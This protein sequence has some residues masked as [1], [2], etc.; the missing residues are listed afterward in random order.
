[1]KK[2]LFRLLSSFFVFALTSCGNTTVSQT[3]FAYSSFVSLNFYNEPSV[4][5]D[6]LEATIYKY[7]KYCDPYSGYE[8]VNNLYTINNATNFIDVD[9]DLLTLLKQSIELENTTEG[10]L[11]PLIG[12]LSLLWK[13]AIENET[14]PS[15]V[16]INRELEIMQNSKLIIE[17]NKVKIE[18]GA[19]LDLGAI[20][21][22]YVLNLLKEKFSKEDIK[23][24][25]ING[26][27]SSIILGEKESGDPFKVGLK[28]LDLGFTAEKTAIGVSSYDEQYFTYN[29]NIYTHV[30]NPFTGSGLA[31]HEMVV[32]IN[33]NATLCDV[34]STVFMLMDQNS[35]TSLAKKNNFEVMVI[36]N[37]SVSYKSEGINLYV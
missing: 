9:D 27:N 2:I 12:G 10:Y 13:E 6:D 14:L 1:M 22:G 8:G 32:V 25:L 34:Y 11:N 17:G 4:N 35:I 23:Y 37:K 20:T 3:I 26:G 19:K 28:N 18:G 7:D 31:N 16:D 29:N 36:D 21:K 30:V 24:Y 15:E 33:D 5:L